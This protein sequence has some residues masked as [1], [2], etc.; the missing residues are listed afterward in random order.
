MGVD[1]VTLALAKKYAKNLVAVGGTITDITR[2]TDGNLEITYT[3]KTGD[4]IVFGAGIVPAGRS[5]ASGNVSAGVLTLTFDDGTSVVVAG[6]L[7]GP[8]GD[9][10]AKG[11]TG[12]QGLPGQGVPTG[13]TTRQVL[14]KKSNLDYDV[15][16]ATPSASGTSTLNATVSGDSGNIISRHWD[17]LYAAVDTSTLASQAEVQQVSTTLSDTKSA[18][19]EEIARVTSQSLYMIGYV[20]TT[21]PPASVNLRDDEIWY[22]ASALDIEFP[23][24]VQTYSNGAWSTTTS[25]MTPNYFDVVALNNN[26]VWQQYYMSATGWVSLSPENISFNNTQFTTTGTTV[27]LADGAIVDANVSDTAGIAQI[28]IAG[29]T[30]ALVQ[31]QTYIDTK[32]AESAPT[33]VT[34]ATDDYYLVLSKYP[35]SWLS[36]YGWFQ[37]AGIDGGLEIDFPAGYEFRDNLYGMTATS[38]LADDGGSID[39]VKSFDPTPTGFKV[40]TVHLEEGLVM[41]FTQEMFSFM[42][43]GHWK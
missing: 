30:E 9:D 36:G 19:Q 3:P 5:I 20:S 16:W 32:L 42:I 17:G 28:K 39:G 6:T 7:T 22:N 35:D 21:E 41:A 23:W 38:M 12:P 33:S 43:T 18:L 31:L 13:G 26:G 4:P 2:N 34:V 15:G 25:T 40:Q 11:D 8:Q 14:T 37:N 24:T 29:L 1:V 10:G 27:N